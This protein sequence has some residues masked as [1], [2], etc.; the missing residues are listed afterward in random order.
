MVDTKPVARTATKSTNIASCDFY[1][2]TRHI[3][4]AG[5]RGQQGGFPGPTHTRHYGEG[6]QGDIHIHPFQVV[7]ARPP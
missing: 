6:T 5:D 1:A 3:N 7:K 4:D 2:S